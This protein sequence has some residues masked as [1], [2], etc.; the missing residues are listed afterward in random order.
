VTGLERAWRVV[1]STWFLC[2]LLFGISWPVSSLAPQAGLDFSFAAGLHMAAHEHLHFGTQIVATYGPLGFLRYPFLYY[3]WTARLALLYTGGVHLLLCLTLI[4][5]LRRML[6]LLIAV[7]LAWVAV[8]IMVTEPESALVVVIVWLIEYLRTGSST[9]VKRAFP[10]IAGVVGGLEVL[11]KLNTGTTIAILA[12]VAI[13]INNRRQ[14]RPIAVFLGSFVATFLIAW[15]ATGQGLSNLGPFIATSRQLI[16]GWST[17]PW[18]TGLNYQL[19]AALVAAVAVFVVAW[20]STP[21][22]RLTTRAGMLLIWLLLGFSTFKEGFVN[23]EPG[24]EM[25]FFGTA[26]GTVFAFTWRRAERLSVMWCLTLVAVLGFAI[27]QADPGTLIDP[28]A[29][30]SA[31]R[32]VIS[33]MASAG[34]RDRVVAEARAKMDTAYGLDPMTLSE[35]AGRGVDVVPS[36]QSILWANRIRWAPIPVYQLYYALTPGLDNLNASVLGSASGPERLLR[37]LSA[38]INY[39]NNLFDS[40]AAQ[41]RMLC[42]YAA[43]STTAAYEVLTRVRNRCGEPR[44]VETVKARWQQFV[45]VPAPQAPNDLVY[46]R[47]SGVAPGGL[48]SLRTLFWRS[49]RRAIGLRQTEGPARDYALVPGTVAD[50]LL[51]S[52]PAAAD[53]PGAFSLAPQ[54]TQL[55]FGK[56]GGSS[57]APLTYRFYEQTIAPAASALAGAGA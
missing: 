2:G 46:V 5:A 42:Q 4:W 34:N 31:L 8:S 36:E 14:W 19:W 21:L 56:S 47:V 57:T 38:P 52:V 15:F 1:T 55:A 23:Q 13:L 9:L 37:N 40:P 50:G 33:T 48:E 6:P 16:G 17:A 51:M 11:V 45:Q 28:S 22:E 25:I 41:R 54:A 20:R 27:T 29:R 3:T 49:Y 44:L 30:A 12:L 26:L 32:E 18:T 35:L 39:R 43:I 10:V 53:F 24:H 7:A